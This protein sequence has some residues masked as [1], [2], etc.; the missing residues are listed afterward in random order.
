MNL[1]EQ[2]K[3]ATDG[4]NGA[5]EHLKGIQKELLSKATPEEKAQY[6]RWLKRQKQQ[7]NK[8]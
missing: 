8:K 7:F 1:K 3:G 6:D 4:L 2:L 5:L